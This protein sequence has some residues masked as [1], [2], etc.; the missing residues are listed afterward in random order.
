M[1]TRRARVSWDDIA[2]LSH[3]LDEA[4]SLLTDLGSRLNAVEIEWLDTRDQVVRSYKRLE[5]A[6]RRAESKANPP[7]TVDT[8]DATEGRTDAF[9]RKLA[10]VREQTSA[11]HAKRTDPASG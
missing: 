11:L 6:E 4:L 8:P 2:R 5:Q 9:S 3:R 7:V 1:W 10:Q